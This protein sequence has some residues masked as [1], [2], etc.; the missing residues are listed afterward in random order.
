MLLAQVEFPLDKKT[1]P[2]IVGEYGSGDSRSRRQLPVPEPRK[3]FSFVKKNLPIDQAHWLSIPEDIKND[4]KVR[5]HTVLFGLPPNG[6]S[7]LDD[8]DIPGIR[9]GNLDD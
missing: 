9:F 5:M 3:L 8:S 7:S 4:E 2:E 1:L 6:A